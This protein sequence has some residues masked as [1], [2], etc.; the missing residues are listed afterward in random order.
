MLS[1]GWQLYM[2]KKILSI[3]PYIK[4]VGHNSKKEETVGPLLFLQITTTTNKQTKKI[5]LIW[6]LAT[7]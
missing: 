4:S 6:F 7:E 5:L 1:E 3:T 2:I